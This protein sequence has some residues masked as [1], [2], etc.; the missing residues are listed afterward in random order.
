[1]AYTPQTWTNGAAGGTPLSAARLAV[2]EAGLVAAAA[3]ADGA[4]S[5]VPLA[6]KAAANGV[7][8]LDAGG[9]VPAAQ[10][11]A[12][13][14]GGVTSVNTRT[15]VVVLAAADVGLGSVNN[16]TDAAKPVSTAQAA[17]DAAVQSAAATD[18]TTK[19]NAVTTTSIGAATAAALTAEA[20]TARAAEVVTNV[21]SYTGALIVVAGKSRVYNDSGRALT[22]TATR[23]S[24]GTAPTGA[25]VIVT[26]DKNGTSIHATTPANR[27]TIAVST[28][29]AAGGTPDTTAWA[30]GE[31]LSVDIAQIG[32]TI[33]GADLTVQVTAK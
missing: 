24:V 23:A 13:T 3:A 32:S 29:T 8:S 19:A 30:A 25:A 20:A 31:Y 21:F 15:G 5:A 4:G 9:L 18:A 1:M 6:Q 33:A 26:I 22:I 2:I 17:A 16:T 28:F 12:T 10:L 11:P 7:A 14:A 27:P